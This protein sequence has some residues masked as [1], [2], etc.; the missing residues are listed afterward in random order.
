MRFAQREV[1][2]L[3][4]LL[5]RRFAPLGICSPGGPLF[6]GQKPKTRFHEPEY[7]ASPRIT[8]PNQV[9]AMDH[10]LPGPRLRSEQPTQTES[11]PRPTLHPGQ[12]LHWTMTLPRSQYLGHKGTP[13]GKCPG[14]GVAVFTCRIVLS[15]RKTTRIAG[16]FY[17]IYRQLCK[18]CPTATRSWRFFAQVFWKQA[19]QPNS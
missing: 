16:S 3:G 11:T 15:M 9:Y 18:C 4:S 12:R 6:A 2:S 7:Q 14:V 8:D 17:S 1:R 10:D 19:T 5:T 13:G